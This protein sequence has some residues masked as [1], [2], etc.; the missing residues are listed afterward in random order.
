MKS[1]YKFLL[2][3]QLKR[4]IDWVEHEE[5]IT[6]S[7][8]IRYEDTN[9]ELHAIMNGRNIECKLLLKYLKTKVDYE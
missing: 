2:E 3:Q 7:L 4:I 6:E 9:S 1:L 8:T 5:R